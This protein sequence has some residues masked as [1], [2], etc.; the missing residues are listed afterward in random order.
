M[1]LPNKLTIF[2]IILVLAMVVISLINI[3]GSVLTIPINMIIMGCIFII[4]SLTD[5]LDG[6][7]ARSR[8]QVTA[9]GKFLDPIADKILV[10]SAMIIFLS[11]DK[12]P[13]WI[14][15]IVIF[16]EFLISGYRLIAVK[17]DGNVIAASIYGKIKT[18][19][20]MVALSLMFIDNYQYGYFILN[21]ID[22]V[23]PMII[24]ITTT[25]LLT[26]SV[27]ATVISGYEYMKNTKDLF[28]D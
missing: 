28:N 22:G 3:P 5:T 4:A 11:Y 16:R 1:N 26:I 23:L 27:I 14:P 2:R 12:I 25:V 15:I 21:Q 13:A 7:L 19:T 6:Y 8:K 24:N 10:I 17:K 18:V 20:Q 9:F